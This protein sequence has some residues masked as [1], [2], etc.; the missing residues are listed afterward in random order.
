MMKED[1]SRCSKKIQKWY[2]VEKNKYMK[3]K[4]I[5]GAL[6]NGTLFGIVGASM[7][8][9]KNDP[10][11]WVVLSSLC[12]IVVNTAVTIRND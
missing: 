10:R 11:Y 8:M 3:I 4:Q 6:I 9:A 12:L 5:A 7:D 2:K 1:F